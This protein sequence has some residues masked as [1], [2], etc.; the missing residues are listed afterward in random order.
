MNGEVLSSLV[1]WLMAI[2]GGGDLV[3]ACILCLECCFLYLI[4]SFGEPSG[5]VRP[6]GTIY[7][8]M[9][10]LLLNEFESDDASLHLVFVLPDLLKTSFTTSNIYF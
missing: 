9:C 4:W 5:N 10:F 1:M 3:Y 7:K 2:S 8:D 6:S